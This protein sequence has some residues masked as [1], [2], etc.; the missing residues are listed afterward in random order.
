M[1]TGREGQRFPKSP[2]NR[3]GPQWPASL[4]APR[5]KASVALFIVFYATDR[6][7]GK[8]RKVWLP[9]PTGLVREARA[10]KAEVETG[11]R[12]S[13]GVWP[14]AAPPTPVEGATLEA[15]GRDWMTRHRPNLRDRVFENYAASLEHHVYPILGKRLMAE[16]GLGRFKTDAAERDVPLF[17]SVRK[18]LLERKARQ[19]FSDAT[20][21][22]FGTGVGTPL[23]PNNF[24]K[25][26]LKPAITRANALRAERG[27]D[28]LPQFRWHDFR[29]Y[30]VSTL[31]A[32][33][34][35]ILTFA[36]IA[37]HSDPTITLKVYGHLMRGALTE[38]AQLYDPL[39]ST[40][41]AAT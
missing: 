25:R 9:E 37:G 2:A 30:A 41:A 26:E 1:P 34:A 33:K 18:L 4:N 39:P 12:R 14:L 6:S 21:Y 22:V 17:R 35:D 7:T 29:H 13:A 10:L 8:C 23:D 36:R 40:A 24:V 3:R 32:Q 31:I 16:L 28:Q 11:L 27:A 15:R 38:A 5:P 20:D 19:R